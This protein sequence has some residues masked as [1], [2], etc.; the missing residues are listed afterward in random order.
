MDGTASNGALQG[1]EQ[2]EVLFLFVREAAE[3]ER[4]MLQV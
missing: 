3:M 1:A 4:V 2:E